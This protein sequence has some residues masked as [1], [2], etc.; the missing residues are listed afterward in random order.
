MFLNHKIAASSIAE[1]VI[2]MTIIALCFGIASLVFIRSTTKTTSFQTVKDQTE[3][4]CI[5]WKQLQLN[6]PPIEIDDFELTSSIDENN[7]S[8]LVHSYTNLYDK[9]VWK[10]QGLRND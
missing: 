2:A 3:I 10:Q 1:V 9:T 6:E 7:D 4:Q 5:V 8:I